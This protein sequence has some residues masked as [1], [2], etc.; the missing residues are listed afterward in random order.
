[1]R[2]S[3][4]LRVARQLTNVGA[5]GRI[6]TAWVQ[7]LSFSLPWEGGSQAA[8]GAAG[9]DPAKS[10]EA[11]VLPNP[12]IPSAATRVALAVA[13]LSRSQRG[14]GVRPSVS[15]RRQ[16]R[17]RPLQCLLSQSPCCCPNSSNFPDRNSRARGVGAPPKARQAAPLRV[18]PAG[19]GHHSD[20]LGRPRRS[21]RVDKK[22]G[23]RELGIW[24]PRTRLPLAAGVRCELLRTVPGKTRR[25][26][27][28]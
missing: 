1:M 28:A 14:P 27:R 12:F 23:N 25:S 9:L 13:E 24:E 15:R 5:K 20:P 18:S 11:G 3:N 7:G 19:L 17:T 10:E 2:L 21:N 26:E 16:A 8:S 6:Q 4:S 22:T